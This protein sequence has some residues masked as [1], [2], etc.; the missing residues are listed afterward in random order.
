MHACIKIEHFIDMLH[1]R[2]VEGGSG[3]IVHKCGEYS[4]QLKTEF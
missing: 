3:G 1:R 4:F 2:T